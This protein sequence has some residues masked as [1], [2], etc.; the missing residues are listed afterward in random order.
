MG[1]G[2]VKMFSALLEA[3]TSFL[4]RGAPPTP[5][6]ASPP[7]P[8]PWWSGPPRCPRPRRPPCSVGS[9]AASP[10]APTPSSRAAG[11]MWSWGKVCSWCHVVCVSYLCLYVSLYWSVFIDLSISLYIYI[12]ISINLWISLSLYKDVSI[13]WWLYLYI[14]INILVSLSLYIYINL[15]ISLSLYI[16]LYWSFYPSIS[17]YFLYI[18]FSVMFSIYLFL[19]TIYSIFL[20]LFN[21]SIYWSL[22]C[23]G[24]ATTLCV[25]QLSYLSSPLTIIWCYDAG[26]LL[27]LFPRHVFSLST[28]AVFYLPLLLFYLLLSRSLLSLCLSLSLCLALSI[29][30]YLSFSLPQFKIAL[31]ALNKHCQKQMINETRK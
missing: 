29:S 12:Y 22:V 31:S 26:Y 19:K 1:T 9:A 18:F 23:L 6:A 16:Y 17:I 10:P 11:C 28:A 3:A 2:W 21:I 30:F 7:A 15:L 24:P 4:C 14:S 25:V 27:G 8:R 5:A 20:S 13:F